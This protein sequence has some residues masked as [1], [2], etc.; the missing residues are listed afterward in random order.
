MLVGIGV[1]SGCGLWCGMDAVNLPASLQDTPR[2]QAQD[3]ID[4]NCTEQ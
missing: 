4:G 1:S 3:H 2:V